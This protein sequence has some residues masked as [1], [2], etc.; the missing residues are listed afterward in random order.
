MNKD[1]LEKRLN[2]HQKL[3]AQIDSRI[4]T[5]SDWRI[6]ILEQIV[7]YQKQITEGGK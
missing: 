2:E 7:V 1:E 5:L 6:N 4:K 3:L